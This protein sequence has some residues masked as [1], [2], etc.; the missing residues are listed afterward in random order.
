LTEIE[1]VLKAVEDLI[2]YTFTDRSLLAQS[3]SHRSYVN[4]NGRP[5]IESNERL[6]FLG[7]SVIEL[8]ITRVLFEDFLDY[9]EGELTKIRSA[10]VRAAALAEAAERLGLGDY[11][12]IGKGEESSG[13][14]KRQSILADTFEAV[15]GALYLDGGFD[16]SCGMVISCLTPILRDIVEWGSSDFKSDLQV[17]SVKRMGLMPRYGMKEKGPDH[18]KTFYATVQ[19]GDR[20][21][22]PVA[23]ASKKE[24]EQG[25][26]RV[27]IIKLGW[28]SGGK[29]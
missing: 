24:A 6:E 8:A 4:E 22:G 20:K 29:H 13:G 25:A 7:D 9:P 1:H 5:S 14:R 12:L 23:G 17:F 18:F 21:F 3:L 28:S 11:I 16:V 27:A 2:G 26:A 19:V 15:V 10:V